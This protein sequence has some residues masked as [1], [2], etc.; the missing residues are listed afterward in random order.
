MELWGL[1]ESTLE[2]IRTSQMKV[3]AGEGADF[4][5]TKVSGKAQSSS[6]NTGGYQT[7]EGHKWSA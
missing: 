7:D 2:K 5:C 3:T 4:G 6:V 1:E